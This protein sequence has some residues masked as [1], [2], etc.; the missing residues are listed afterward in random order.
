M[1][2][3]ESRRQF[4]ASCGAS[5]T[6]GVSGCLG[7][8][9]D[10]SS[11]TNE[12][13]PTTT[14]PTT[15]APE[16]GGYPDVDERVDELPPGDPP[17][18]PSGFWPSFRYDAGNTG[19]NPDGEGLRDGTTSWR[20]N[21]GRAATVANGTLYNVFSR[22]TEPSE[23]TLRDPATASVET[24]QSLVGYGVNDPPVV[25]DGRVF[26]NTF[27]EV[28]C[29]DAQT[30]EQ[31]WRGPEMDG[32]QGRP[33]VHDGTVFVN[34]GG[35]DQVEPHIRAFDVETGDEQWRYDIG[36][37]TKSTPAV[38]G[39][40]V[41]VTGSGGVYAIDQASGDEVFTLADVAARWGS[42]VADNGVLYA[43]DEQ[44]DV[45]DLVAIEIASRDE[46][47]RQEIEIDSPPVVTPERIYTQTD[48]QV[49]GLDRED[50][51]VVTSGSDAARPMGLVGDVLY[52]ARNGTVGALDV[53]NDM[54]QLWS[55]RTQ[56]VQISDTIGRH[57][58]D[59][60]P[61]DGA[62]FV[63]A[64]DAFYGIGPAE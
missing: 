18:S 7:A 63:S 52:T 45:R 4:L 19:S 2:V 59:I 1:N 29:F 56:E 20:L 17:L 36:Q 44:S 53:S 39:D 40:N 49:V 46:L 15:E 31:L 54:E 33:T 9:G 58:Y 55:I 28:F 10:G 35:F 30:G 47:W 60:T 11:P 41:F 38:D 34:S 24:S 62:V 8:G 43:A 61:V 5:L 26:V 16:T 21:A 37:E 22:D 6:I 23:L 42:P 12:P 14:P 50:G 13:T 32:I 25:S 48:G 51:E 27:I 3:R 57:V 64:R